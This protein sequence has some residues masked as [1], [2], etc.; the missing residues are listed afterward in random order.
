MKIRNVEQLELDLHFEKIERE[1]E[2][3]RIV[4]DIEKAVKLRIVA[5]GS[6]VDFICLEEI[7][8]PAE[9]VLHYIDLNYTQYFRVSKETGAIWHI[10]DMLE[11]AGYK[12]VGDFT[13]EIPTYLLK[14][15]KY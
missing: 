12:K 13:Y 10:R 4:E 2:I 8:G 9:K 11:R 15:N 5:H 14:S 7:S 3:K 1:R 6:R